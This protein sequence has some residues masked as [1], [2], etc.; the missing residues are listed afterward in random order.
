[1]VNDFAP[2]L[3]FPSDTAIART[4]LEIVRFAIAFD[5]AQDLEVALAFCLLLDMGEERQDLQIRGVA[6]DFFQNLAGSVAGLIG[7][8]PVLQIVNFRQ[9]L[10]TG[11]RRKPRR[12]SGRC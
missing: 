5:L 7:H 2:K 1:M 9:G 10:I 8:E 4:S 12:C 6:K 11:I 3:E